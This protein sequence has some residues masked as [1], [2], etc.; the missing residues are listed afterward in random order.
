VTQFSLFGAAAADPVAADLDGV[1][2]AGGQWVRAGTAARL[3]VVVADLWRAR[4]LAAEFVLRGAGGQSAAAE[5]GYS[6]RTDFATD[7]TPHAVRWTRGA[8]LAPPPGL[9]LSATG[10][11]LWA[12]AA[13]RADDAGYLLG[14][15]DADGPVHLAAGAQLARLGV[16]GVSLGSRGGPGWRV[17]SAKRIRRLAELV[18]EH[19]EGAAGDWPKVR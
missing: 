14:T 1:L 18:G 3:S 19:P 11:R 13:G 5:H 9:A 17:S 2:L 8:N 6:V 16:T 15:A 10:L 4:A 7:L 12:L